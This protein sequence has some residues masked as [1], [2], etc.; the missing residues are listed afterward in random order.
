MSNNIPLDLQRR[1]ERRWAAHCELAP[2]KKPLVSQFTENRPRTGSPSGK[3]E[4]TARAKPT[5]HAA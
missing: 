2:R 1:F 3:K 5:D 4:I